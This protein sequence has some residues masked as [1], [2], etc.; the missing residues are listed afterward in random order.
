MPESTT[1][2]RCRELRR[3][4]GW[5]QEDLAEHAGISVSPVRKL[6]QG[7]QVR[8]ETL[9]AIA[10]ALNVVTVTF[11][12]P[13][14]PQPQE[15]SIDDVVL[16]DMR[17]AIHPPMSI[18]GHP[19]LAAYL[20]DPDLQQLRRS[21]Q[22]IAAAYHADSYDHLATVMPAVVRAAH[23]HVEALDT[24]REHDEA[25][26]LRSDITGLAGRYLIQIRAHDLALV[27]LH[28]SLQD[29]IEIGDTSLAAAAVSSQAWAMLRQGR[30]GE[31]ERLCI[32]AA[33]EIEP[34]MSTAT[35]DQLA[36]WGWLLVR[37]AAAASR[38]N[39]AQE[40]RQYASVARTAG[41][42]MER[43]IDDLAGHKSFGPISA[44][45]IG[46]E[47]ELL[48]DQPDAALQLAEQIPRG[49]G[50]A[51]TST[52]TRH[53]IDVARAHVGVGNADRATEIMTKLK[54][55]HPEWLRY[56][57]PARDAVREI[58]ATRPR[59]P[60]NEQRQLAEFMDV[61]G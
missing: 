26:R 57:Q 5:S 1:A 13:T 48:A 58:L 50:T 40:A 55:R 20:G 61:E 38:N 30:L 10:R 3:R 42:R 36:S 14:A 35:H 49:A 52:W 45:V 51:S 31:V 27:A 56:Q 59:M 39:R 15:A 29:A 19:V 7:G 47:V 46:P 22:S 8:M 16:S 53:Q 41:T 43:E 34:K 25:L 6:E 9:H 4:R 21:V 54:Q 12:S 37:A 44:G 2:D 33:D 18:S 11:V 28:R 60:S 32:K 24:G 17:S 23:F